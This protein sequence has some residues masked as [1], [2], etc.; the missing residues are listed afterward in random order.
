MFKRKSEFVKVYIFLQTF[1]K[2]EAQIQSNL[3]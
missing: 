3:Y 1:S 2:Q